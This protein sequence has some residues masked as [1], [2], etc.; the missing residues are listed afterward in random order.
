MSYTQHEACACENDVI[1]KNCQL[2]VFIDLVVFKF[3]FH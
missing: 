2:F 3:R 1:S